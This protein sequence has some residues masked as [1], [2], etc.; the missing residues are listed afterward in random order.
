[1]S[2]LNNDGLFEQVL[3]AQ[4]TQREGWMPE[5]KQGELVARLERICCDQEEEIDRLKKELGEAKTDANALY[6][7]LS[8]LTEHICECDESKL[9]ACDSDP[10]PPSVFHVYSKSAMTALAKHEALTSQR[11]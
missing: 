8:Q 6:N 9:L 5:I 10:H 3:Q 1:M 2:N 11:Q 7:E 4:E